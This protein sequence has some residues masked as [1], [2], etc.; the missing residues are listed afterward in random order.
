MATSVWHIKLPVMV[1]TCSQLLT[2][3]TVLD[4]YGSMQT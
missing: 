2:V 3:Y 1:D 4:K